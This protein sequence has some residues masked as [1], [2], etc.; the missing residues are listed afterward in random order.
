MV[1]SSHL[2]PLSLRQIS[3]QRICYPLLETLLHNEK[4]KSLAG[5]LVSYSRGLTWQE[6]GD[7][8]RDCNVAVLLSSYSSVVVTV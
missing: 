4:K 7:A 6:E 5:T 3:L 2:K 8:L 1:V